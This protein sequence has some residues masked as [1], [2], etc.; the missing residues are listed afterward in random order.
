MSRV[1][2]ATVRSSVPTSPSRTVCPS[3]T[4]PPCER[5]GFESLAA[6]SLARRP[7]R[8]EITRPRID[9][10]VS[11]PIPPM[12][13][14]MK[15]KTLPSG[16]NVVAMSTVVSPVTQMVDTA[17]NSASARGRRRPSALAAGSD[18]RA[19]NSRMSEANTSTAKRAGEDVVRFRRRSHAAFSADVARRTSDPAGSVAMSPPSPRDS[20][21]GTPRG[22]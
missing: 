10:S 20:R 21:H 1:D 15:M 12:L 4:G 3:L 6:M 18:S 2:R 14:P 17:V 5:S 7:S 16:E 8:F 19:V 13:T 9:A 11:T 22:S